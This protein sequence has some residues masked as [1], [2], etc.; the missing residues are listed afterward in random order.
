MTFQKLSWT[1]PV[2]TA[3]ALDAWLQAEAEPLPPGT[4]CLVGACAGSAYGRV[5][6]CTYHRVVGAVTGRR[7]A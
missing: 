1:S 4:P 6:L 7:L 2:S 5:L 3:L